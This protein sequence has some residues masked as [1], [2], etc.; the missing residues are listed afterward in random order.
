MD[1]AIDH[2]CPSIVSGSCD[3]DCISDDCTMFADESGDVVTEYALVEA[4]DYCT[5]CTRDYDAMSADERAAHE[6][7]GEMV[8]T[9]CAGT[10]NGVVWS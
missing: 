10:T 5:T 9:T 6:C 1:H 2:V 3:I 4:R 7:D 8:V